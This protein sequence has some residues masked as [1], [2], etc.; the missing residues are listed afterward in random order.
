LTALNSLAREPLTAQTSHDARTTCLSA[1]IEKPVR[2]DM[3]GLWLDTL[4]SLRA[5]DILRFKAIIHMV[6]REHPSPFT[7]CSTSFIHRFRCRTG[8][9]ATATVALQPCRS[10][11]ARRRIGRSRQA[12]WCCVVR[13]ACGFGAAQ[14]CWLPVGPHR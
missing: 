2:A 12:G 6:E 4:M 1:V 3:F 13:Q 9:R 14:P 5:E 11:P 10:C 7:G 8:R